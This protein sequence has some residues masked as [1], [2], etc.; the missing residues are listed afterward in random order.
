MSWQRR[1]RLQSGGERFERRASA[2]D[3][4]ASPRNERAL[5]RQQQLP[6]IAIFAILCG[7]LLI[8]IAIYL[9]YL[10]VER[11]ARRER[12]RLEALQNPAAPRSADR[13]QSILEIFK[14]FRL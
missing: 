11:R 10:L 12:E 7:V 2:D 5:C 6:L 13:K 9:K 4:A 8:I 14:N 3:R 1:R